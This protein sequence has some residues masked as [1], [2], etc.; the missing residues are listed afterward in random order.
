MTGEFKKIDISETPD[1]DSS[2]IDVSETSE[3][4][5]PEETLTRG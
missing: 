3:R 4:E 2:R 1:R 5:I